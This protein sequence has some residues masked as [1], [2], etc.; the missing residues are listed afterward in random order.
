MK[1]FYISKNYADRF[2]ASSKAKYDCEII[3]ESLGYKNIGLNRKFIHNVIIGRL[4]TL[5]SNII[6]LLRMP[7]KGIAILQYPVAFFNTQVFF[8][9]RKQNAIIVII[10]DIPALKKEAFV[11][12]KY[13]EQ[14]DITI[15]HSPR[16]EEWCDNN[17]NCRRLIVLEMFDYLSNN[18]IINLDMKIEPPIRIAFAGNLKRSKFLSKIKLDSILE[19]DLYGPRI[20]KRETEKN[21]Q[22]KG[23]YSPDE[24]CSHMNCL[25]GLVWNGDSIDKCDGIEG[26][27]LKYIAPHK[28][29]MYLSCGIPVIVWRHAAMAGLVEK[30]NIGV[31][32]NSLT[33]LNDCLKTISQERYNTLKMN[34]MSIMKLV[35]SGHFLRT[36]VIKSESFL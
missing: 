18:Q 25:Y 30:Y 3:L 36:A 4:Y 5:L 14:A 11:G 21:I 19:L 22:Y 17:M 13:I 2:T 10:H 24:L 16:M 32:I 34:A 28:M 23:C 33:D 9:R 27:Y 20:E 15:V 31:I 6:A 26:E 1:K 29:S 8:A 7:K 35:R 12:S